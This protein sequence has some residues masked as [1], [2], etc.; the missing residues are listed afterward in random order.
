MYLSNC[1]VGS[2]GEPVDVQ[3]AIYDSAGT[4]L[5]ATQVSLGKFETSRKINVFKEA[6]LAPGAYSNIR[7]TFTN[8]GGQAVPPSFRYCTME[9]RSNSSADF[10]IAKSI[11]ANDQRQSRKACYG[12]SQCG[13]VSAIDKSTVPDASTRNIHYTIFD[14]PDFI[15]CSLVYNQPSD[16]GK[17]EIMVRGPGSPTSTTPFVLTAPYTGAPFTAGGASAQSFYIYTGERSTQA[18]GLSTRWYIDVQIDPLSGAAGPVDY[19]IT[20]TSGNGVTIPWM[21]MTSGATP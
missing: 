12:Q 4:L 21:G 18:G 6:G 9:S 8:S 20:C 16:N 14:Q 13:T 3:I 11:D 10:R 1:F 7:A 15:Q 17:L 2:L 19:G 5:G